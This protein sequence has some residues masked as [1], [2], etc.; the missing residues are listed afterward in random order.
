MKK[1]KEKQVFTEKERNKGIIRTSLVGIGGN[2]LLVAMKATVGFIAGSV[3]I[4]MDALNNLTDALSSIITIIGTK[5]S[6][7]N[8]DKKHPYGHGRVEY[9]TSSLIGAVILFAGG[10]A[11]YKSIESIINHFKTGELPSYDNYAFF[12]ISAAIVIKIGLGIFYQIKGKK[13]NSSVLKASGLD[14]LFDSLLTLSTL[15]GAIVS[16][17]AS[18]YVEGYIGVVIGIFILRTGFEIVR[19]AISNLIGVRI[20]QEFANEI[21]AE[22]AQ[23]DGV[24]GVYDLILNNYGHSKFIGSVHVGVDESLTAKDIHILERE[25]GVNLYLK[26]NIIMTVGIYC[27]TVSSPI[28]NEIKNKIIELIKENPFILQLHG[29]YIDEGTKSVYFDLVFDYQEKDPVSAVNSLVIKL[30][31][32]FEGYSFYPVIDRDF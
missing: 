10:S 5:L 22:I 26:H 30:V 28:G 19:E 6:G 25:I 8:P 11:I 17:F 20:D 9:I 21:K 2:A 23:F 13:Y 3:S 29:F 24:K 18:T 32:A 14:A 4:I 1:N 27:E 12:L 7:K 31:E 16:R 15:I